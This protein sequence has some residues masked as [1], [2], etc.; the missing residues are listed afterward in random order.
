[1]P[2]YSKELIAASSIPL[3]LS[4][5]SKEESYGYEII[6]K[7]RDASN[8]ELQFAEG[9]LYPILKKLEE[10]KIIVSQ[11]RKADNDRERKYYKVTARGLKQLA[12]EKNNWSIVH[13]IL[14]SLWQPQTFSYSMP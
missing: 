11:W 9:T 12:V 1:M 14:T 4:I 3:I 2:D 6:R 8:N 10:K 5:L 7:I 13:S